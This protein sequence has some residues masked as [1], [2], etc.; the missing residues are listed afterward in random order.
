MDHS[1][2]R[3][4]A[5]SEAAPSIRVI[6]KYPNRRLYDTAISSYITLED[7]KNLVVTGVDFRVIDS[8][9]AEDLTRPILFQII[10]EQEQKSGPLLSNAFLVQLIRLYGDTLQGAIRNYFEFV[11][12]VLVDQHHL[13]RDQMSALVETNPVSVMLDIA[14]RNLALW[15]GVRE[16]AANGSGLASES[17]VA[18]KDRS[19]ADK[20]QT[21]GKP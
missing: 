7:V 10:A 13:L 15:S 20:P 2:Q 3:T 14:Q 18:S 8:R 5:A 19:S 1:V 16:S 9:T 12:Q 17:D 11:A 6:K 4:A 21:G